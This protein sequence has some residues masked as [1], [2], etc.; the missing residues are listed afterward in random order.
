MLGVRENKYYFGFVMPIA[1]ELKPR[2]LSIDLIIPSS[3]YRSLANT[4]D[5]TL[6]VI[7]I[8]ALF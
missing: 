4:I 5:I 2:S 6:S 7:L 8:S 3:V 1:I